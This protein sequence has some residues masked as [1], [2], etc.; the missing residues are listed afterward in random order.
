M[1]ILYTSYFEIGGHIVESQQQ[2][3]TTSLSRAYLP[4]RSRD[5]DALRAEGTNSLGNGGT[6]AGP[7]V[8]LVP[9]LPSG[10]RKMGRARRARQALVIAG[11]L[12]AADGPLPVGDIFAIGLLSGYAGYEVYRIVTD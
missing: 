5:G 2:G 8:Y 7:E 9:H 4:F 1:K 11:A 10:V 3:P 12:A 6:P